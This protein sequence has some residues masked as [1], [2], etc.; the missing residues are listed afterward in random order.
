M[1]KVSKLQEYCERN[2]GKIAKVSRRLTRRIKLA[3]TDGNLG[4]ARIGVAAYVFLLDNS[5]SSKDKSYSLNYFTKELIQP[6]DAVINTLLVEPRPE[7]RA[8]GAELLSAFIRAQSEVEN[9]A[10]AVKPLVKT[11][12][13]TLVAPDEPSASG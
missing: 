8:L 2:P 3:L 9:Q 1:K 4:Y 6:P 11:L 12:C 7:V 10:A 5:S 13:V